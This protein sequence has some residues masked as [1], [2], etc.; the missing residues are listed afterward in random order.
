M[1]HLK[2]SVNLTYLFLKCSASVCYGH[3]S[4]AYSTDLSS[5]L[6]PQHYQKTQV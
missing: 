6:G 5:K 3:H 1:K 4:R 2:Y